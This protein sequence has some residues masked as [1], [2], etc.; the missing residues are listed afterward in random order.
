MWCTGEYYEGNEKLSSPI[1]WKKHST[2]TGTVPK[3]GESIDLDHLIQKDDELDYSTLPRLVIDP[4]E[5]LEKI[6]GNNGHIRNQFLQ[7]FNELYYHIEYEDVLDEID[8]IVTIFH[9]LSLL[10]DDIEDDSS[11]RRGWPAAHTKYGV[12][13]TINC[14]NLMYFVAMKRATSVLPEIYL[15]H[16]PRVCVAELSASIQKIL[17][18]EM[19]NLHHGQ[20]LDIYWRD[21]PNVIENNLPSLTEYAEMVMN[22]TGGLFRLSIKLLELFSTSETSQP[23]KI[24]LAN[25]LGII[26][27]IRDDYLNLVDERYNHMKGTSGEDLLEGKASLPILHCL[28]NSEKSPVYRM[29]TEYKTSEER[30]K[31]DL[32]K[33]AIQFME[34]E[35][36]SLAFTKHLLLEYC[37]KARNE[38]VQTTGNKDSM[39]IQIIHKL[40]M[41]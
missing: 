19:I 8:H 13:L 11:F 21:T 20:G 4:Y 22:K 29:L 5:Y 17:T 34:E 40:S 33:V 31:S 7:A 30:A 32:L 25:L 12:P 23:S 36:Q 37:D 2:G 1:R 6:P 24:P 28:K 26:Y 9:E 3:M 18:N 38:I 10:I 14:G 15:K 27:Q 41:V 39:L 35:T 16:N